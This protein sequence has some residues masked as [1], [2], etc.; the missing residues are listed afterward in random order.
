MKA[1]VVV[2]NSEFEQQKRKKKWESVSVNAKVGP[3]GGA[4]IPCSVVTCTS[5][6]YKL[7]SRLC[8]VIITSWV[9]E[10][11]KKKRKRE[12]YI[13]FLLKTRLKTNVLHN[14]TSG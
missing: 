13:V 14:K 3:A 4:K 1:L 5:A 11:K 9:E 2:W 7:S 8:L 12:P 10:K 6:L